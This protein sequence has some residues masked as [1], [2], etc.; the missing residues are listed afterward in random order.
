M[1]TGRFR[2]TIYAH[3]KKE[4]RV[5]PWRKTRDPYRILVSEVMLQQTQAPR[6]VP[7]YEE[8]I[9]AFPDFKALGKATPAR[10]L[11]AWQGLGYN[12][13]ALALRRLAK[14]V[15]ANHKGTLPKDEAALVALPGVGPYTARAV[16]A[17]AF[18]LADPFIETN[19][20]T[21]FIHFFF[22]GRK[23]VRDAEIFPLIERTLDRK[24]PR[25]WYSALMDYGVHL[26]KTENFSR[27]SAHY[28]KQSKFKGSRREVRG[29][30]IKRLL[31]KKRMPAAALLSAV[32]GAKA[33][34]LA[35][36]AELA[37]EGIIKLKK[38]EYSL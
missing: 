3:F 23:E 20:R 21:V 26:K 38:G 8:F 7:K 9:K 2:R 15:M 11:R 10:V 31:E 22:K 17:F 30:I 25:L 36:A 13:R 28:K 19:I 37:R 32:G 1:E 33:Q 29:T 14:E 5:F 16:R 27:Q 4:M 34:V 12:R 18:N 6:A 35:A 24:N